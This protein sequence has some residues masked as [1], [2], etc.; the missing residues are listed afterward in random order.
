MSEV[1][2]KGYIKQGEF[3]FISPRYPHLSLVMDGGG[4]GQVGSRTVVVK[5]RFVDFFPGPF[6]G[7]FRTKDKELASRLRERD[8][9]DDH[10]QEVASD[11]ELSA[12]ADLRDKIV[13]DTGDKVVRGIGRKAKP[14][15]STPA[16][17][18]AAAPSPAA[19]RGPAAVGK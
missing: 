18:S 16:P 7:E 12:L 2:H 10:Y 3:L 17:Q 19:A 4:I 9:V 1:D 6:G 13:E 15:V 11:E 14:S 8:K 5:P